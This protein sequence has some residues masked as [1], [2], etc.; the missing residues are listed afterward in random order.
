MD[1]F[2]VRG[3]IVNFTSTVWLAY[4]ESPRIFTVA[5]AS[6]AFTFTL[7]VVGYVIA[8]SE[9]LSVTPFNVILKS[10]AVGLT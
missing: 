2:T 10:G 6:P 7:E 8:K 5:Y 1:S 9:A 4:V 3:L